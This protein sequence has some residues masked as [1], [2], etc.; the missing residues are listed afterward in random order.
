MLQNLNSPKCRA[1]SVLRRDFDTKYALCNTD[2][3]KS[4]ALEEIKF[5][6][7]IFVRSTS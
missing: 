6:L 4:V 2:C 3:G 5:V 7:R 1:Y